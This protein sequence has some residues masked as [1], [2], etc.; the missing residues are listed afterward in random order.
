MTQRVKAFA[1]KPDNL[2]SIRKTYLMEGDNQ[3]LKIV[4]MT[5]GMCTQVLAQNKCNNFKRSNIKKIN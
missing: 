5:H 1:A 4:L 3:F 2:S